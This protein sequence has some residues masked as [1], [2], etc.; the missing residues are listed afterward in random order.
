[1]VPGPD[2]DR[3]KETRPLKSLSPGTMISHYR[4]IEKIGAGGMGV[5]YKAEDT[6]LKRYVALKFLP[7]GLTR[8]NEAK[9]RF[10]QEAQAA[11]S[12]DHPNICN[13]HEI[14]EPDDGQM[15]IVMACY[16]GES[17][18]EKLKRGPLDVEQALDIAIQ[19]AQ[20]LSKA[21]EKGIIHRDIKPGNIM[22]T[23][24]GVVKVMDFGLAKLTGQTRITKAG[25]VLGTVAY[26]S[27]EQTQGAEVD[28]RT[29]IWSLGVILYEM[30]IGRPPFRGD[31]EQAVIYS[32]LNDEPEPPIAA[33]S[34]ALLLVET[35]VAQ[36]L[37]KDPEKRYQKAAALLADLQN[38]KAGEGSASLR[39]YASLATHRLSIGVLPFV[40]MSPE[41]DQEYFCDGMAEELIN[42]LAKIRE[43]RVVSRT[44]AFQFKGKSQNVK[45]IG[46]QL[47]VQALLEGSVRKAGDRL[48]ITAELV[49]VD[50]GYQLW[51]DKYD[52]DIRDVFAIQDE[53]SLAIV[54]KLKINLLGGEKAE[55]M[56]R[57][58]DDLEAYNLYLRGR[59]FWNKRTERGL[60]KAIVCFKQAVE[61]APDYALAYVGL[62]DAYSALPDYSHVAPAEVLPTS[63]EA[64]LKALG[65]DEKLAEAHA[66]LGMVIHQLEWDWVAAEKHLR[67]AIQLNPEYAT[68]HHFYGIFLERMARFDASIRE[69]K[70]A[71]S[72]DPLSLVINRNFGALLFYAREYDGA[73]EALQ[74]TL[75]MD[76]G[77]G[78][79]HAYLGEAYLE[80]GMFEEA[81]EELEMERAISREWRADTEIRIGAGYARVGRPEKAR[82][83]LDV[84]LER[85]K[86]MY[87]SPFMLAL[88]HFALEEKDRGFEF[89]ERA[90]E[91]RDTSLLHL[92][93]EPVLDT[94]RS[95]PRYEQMLNRIGLRD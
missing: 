4:I 15:F 95:D 23:T 47:R 2:E 56:K 14:D 42:A 65:I 17:L 33:G 76:P 58:T 48:R 28:H 78:S 83:I 86:R 13:I 55:L 43:L 93:I 34:E 10:I 29:D 70:K 49:N 26:M 24:D 46:K 66:S 73:I 77:F 30:L 54:E 18:R 35:I 85:S 1:M 75:E 92:K 64:A 67:R 12:L 37:V 27:P 19:V 38:A 53:I 20:G 91:F 52:R 32:I 94:V 11:S 7:L 9:E 39:G 79:T 51:S 80:N 6:R 72:L 25:T 59:F 60:R 8:D 36:T 62:A 71:L 88:L 3:L 63:K 5:V 69:M 84:L 16:D 50:N 22:V 61:R 82:E 21:H 45:E 57:H 89:L 74:R 81:L 44:S 31:Y 90:Y 87:I 68:A 40:D 41:R